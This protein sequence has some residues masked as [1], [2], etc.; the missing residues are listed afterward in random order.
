VEQL[1]PWMALAALIGGYLIGSIPFGVI[2]ARL[3]GVGDLRKVGSGNIGATNVLRT[4]RKDLALITLIGDGGKGAAAALLAWQLAE[5]SGVSGHGPVIAACLAGGGAFVGH[6]FPVWLRFRGGKGVATFFG[7]LLA[8]AWPV[9][10]L[11]G[12]TWLLVAFLFRYSSLAALVAAATAPVYAFAADRPMPVVYLALFMAVLI[13]LRH[14]ANMRRL[15]KG[16]EPKIGRKTPPA[17]A[18][19]A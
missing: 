2:A 3:G 4:G 17:P 7:V 14:G 6:L 13:Y 12:A 16:E 15:I 1:Q 19:D 9:G 8:V 18:E 5:R 10:F 11:A